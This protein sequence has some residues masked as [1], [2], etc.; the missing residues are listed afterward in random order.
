[1][2]GLR[3]EH[4]I[5]L[6]VE[7]CVFVRCHSFVVSHVVLTLQASNTYGPVL[8]RS[9]L[10]QSNLFNLQS[11]RPKRQSCETKA[12]TQRV[13][14]GAVFGSARY[15]TP[16]S[17]GYQPYCSEQVTDNALLRRGYQP[18]CSLQV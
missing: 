18:Y 9:L 6:P 8:L 3:V 13:A 12:K 15:E 1:M 2:I 4:W 14:G 11:S 10:Q 16:Q 17:R 5:G 7:R